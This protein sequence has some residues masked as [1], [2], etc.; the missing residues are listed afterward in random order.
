MVNGKYINYDYLFLFIGEQLAYCVKE[1]EIKF[2]SITK[3]YRYLYI[4]AVILISNF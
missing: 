3:S 4:H 1:N 2:D